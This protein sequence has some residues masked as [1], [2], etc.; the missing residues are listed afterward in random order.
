M[1]ARYERD[2]QWIE[3]YVARYS[4]Q[5]QD[6]ELLNSEN[7]ID[8]RMIW[9]DVPQQRRS[10]ERGAGERVGVVEVRLTVPQLNRHIWG[11][12]FVGDRHA[13]NGLMVKLLD[14]AAWESQTFAVIVLPTASVRSRS[15]T[16]K[17]V[18]ITG[19][20]W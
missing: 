5:R 9:A 4:G 16:I 18:Q 2:D 6:A 3:V 17:P 20:R 1:L 10:V 19:R 13:S 11:W 14:D 8:R 15:S 7:M 12:Y